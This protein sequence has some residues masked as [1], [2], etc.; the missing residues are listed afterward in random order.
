MVLF[1]LPSTGVVAG[2]TNVEIAQCKNLEIYAETGLE[3]NDAI[4]AY[5]DH[6]NPAQRI[7]Y[8]DYGNFTRFGRT[9]T[10]LQ[11]SQS[12][13]PTTTLDL[14]NHKVIVTSKDGKAERFSACRFDSRGISVLKKTAKQSKKKN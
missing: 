5:V 13:L 12:D 6:G 1:I 4:E 9:K 3:Y 10:I 11:L 8:N 14:T 7:T 2:T